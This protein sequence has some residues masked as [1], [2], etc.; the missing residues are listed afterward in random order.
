MDDCGDGAPNLKQYILDGQ[1]TPAAGEK[2]GTAVGEFVAQLHDWGK[3]DASALEFFHSNEQAKRISSWA[4]Y[5][6][7]VSTVDGTAGLEALQDPP[8]VA[9]EKEL[10]VISQVVAETTQSMMTAKDTVSEVLN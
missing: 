1:C 5:G 10:S 9:S 2:I 8:L 7:L 6:R 4:F 3:E